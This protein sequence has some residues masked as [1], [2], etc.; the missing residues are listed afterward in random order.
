M[1]DQTLTRTEAIQELEEYSACDIVTAE[2]AQ[3]LADPFGVELDVVDM[4]PLEDVVPLYHGAYHRGLSI[5][6]LVTLICREMGLDTENPD[7]A[8]LTDTGLLSRA[9]YEH[10]IPKLRESIQT[11]ITH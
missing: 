6:A 2:N 11:T 8:G 9:T 1:T 10:N 3:A 5:A 4:H 7:T